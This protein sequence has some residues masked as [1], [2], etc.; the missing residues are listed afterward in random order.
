MSVSTQRTAL[1][2][3]A[4]DPLKRLV[5]TALRSV[6]YYVLD[7]DM[8]DFDPSD[9]I[10]SGG[11]QGVGL[12]F[13]GGEA[14]LDWGFEQEMRDP[15]G[16]LAYHLLVRSVSE[17]ENVAAISS[18]VATEAF[19]WKQIRDEILLST[20]VWGVVLDENRPIPQAV[21]LAFPSAHIFVTIGWTGDTL[22]VGDG[23]EVLVLDSEQWVRLRKAQHPAEDGMILLWRSPSTV[24]ER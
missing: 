22:C 18:V 8:A 19:P 2:K 6:V 15:T 20:T 13:D 10:T 24:T 16:L 5:G 1:Q 3:F 11:C 9:L 14:E 4:T 17:R 21:E 23:D 7:C 12:F